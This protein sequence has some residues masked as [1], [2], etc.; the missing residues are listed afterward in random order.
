MFFFSSVHILAKST[1]IPHINNSGREKEGVLCRRKEENY[2]KKVFKK[3][4]SVVLAVCMSAG[5]TPFITTPVSAYSGTH[6]TAT[7]Y[8]NSSNVIDKVT[9]QLLK[10]RKKI[11]VYYKGSTR[12]LSNKMTSMYNRGTFTHNQY[13]LY[14]F[15][16]LNCRRDWGYYKKGW[17]RCTISPDYHVTGAQEAATQKKVKSILKS[18]HLKGSNYQK[19]VKI[20][21]YLVL[22]MTYPMNPPYYDT[23]YD[24]LVKNRG[25]C[26]GFSEAFHLLATN[27]GIRTRMVEGK[28]YDEDND[29]WVPHMWNI[30]ESDGSLY[31]IDVTYNY[32]YGVGDHTWLKKGLH[33]EDHKIGLDWFK[34]KDSKKWF[35]AIK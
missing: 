34:I 22:H 15:K 4:S 12:S 32:G 29:V 11:T 6:G 26:Q 21:D 1:P 7:V 23:A 20:N 8:T 3:F 24:A 30:F 5:I 16:K 9:A 33:L 18:L 35:N 19:A 28:G 14:T 17:S 2:M 13:A 31:S 10:R 25:V 27:A